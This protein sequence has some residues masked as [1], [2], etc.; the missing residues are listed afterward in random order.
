MAPHRAQ[1]VP[2]ARRAATA[3]LAPRRLRPP[4]APC[5][6]LAGSQAAPAALGA[7]WQVA[8]VLPTSLARRAPPPVQQQ[9]ALPAP[10]AHFQLLAPL[11]ALERPVT[12]AATVCTTRRRATFARAAL[13]AHRSASARS[14]PLYAAV[15]SALWA[16]SA[17]L[18]RRAAQPRHAT[19]ASL[20]RIPQALVV[21]RA[22]ARPAAPVASEDVVPPTPLKPRARSAVLAS[23]LQ[24]GP[25]R[26]RHARQDRRQRRVRQPARAAFALLEPTAQLA[27]RTQCAY[28]APPERGPTRLGQQCAWARRARG[29]DL[30]RLALRIR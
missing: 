15:A 10:A 3:I 30:V 18:A 9:R 25:P 14:H 26:A 7:Q 22:Q 24:R 27:Q 20:A 2:C 21:A 5:A 6:R 16:L 8:R 12:P 28:S 11:L 23:L 17:R 4:R 29:E 19:S 13:G 1:A